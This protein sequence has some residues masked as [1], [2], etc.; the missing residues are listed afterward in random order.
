M[1]TSSDKAPG[2]SAG[3]SSYGQI[4]TSS[5]IVGGAQAINYI[6]G[7][8]RTKLVAVLLGPTGMGLVAV[9]VS[10]IGIVQT[11]AQ[12]GVN[13][14]G[15]REVAAAFGTNNNQRLAETVVALR[16][17]CWITGFAGW[18]LA[19]ALAWPLSQWMF[20]SAEH[21]WAIGILGCIVL[22][23]S[24]ANGQRALLQGIRRI[25]DIARVQIASALIATVVAAV[26]YWKL[27]EA[28][29]VPVIVLTSLIQLGCFWWFA[30]RIH[31]ADP[32]L[33]WRR[34]KDHWVQLIKLG[35]AVLYGG[36]V[37]SAT[38]LVVRAL[39]VRDAGLGGA[40]IYHAA[41]SL[42]GLFGGFVLQ[43]MAMDFLPRLTAIADDNAVVNRLVNE[44]VEI[45]VLL[46]L[47]AVLLPL[48]VAPW[49]VELLFSS[50]FATASDLLPGML[51]GVLCG[52]VRTP[53][54][55]VAIAKKATGYLFALR[56]A[57]G[58]LQVGVFWIM[59]KQFG[60]VGAAWSY[61]LFAAGGVLLSL[62][63]AKRLSDFSCSS[64]TWRRVRFS[65][66]FIGLALLVLLMLQ[67]HPL[68]RVGMML[69][70]AG[71]TYLSMRQLA[72]ISPEHFDARKVLAKITNKIRPRRT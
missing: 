49:L 9:Y 30:R 24:I 43:A 61:A 12:L 23:D 14:S 68:Y 38:G 69:L 65:A 22:I 70:A 15:V 26:L 44:Q 27:G 28:G 36:L 19:I 67:Y 72:L 48:A 31:L 6:I 2:N 5:A 66:T 18:V 59:F 41:W 20:K 11:A 32:Q 39:L 7:L 51:L 35:T 56:T 53:L 21:V 62:L 13:Q 60:L 3:S 17:L 33:S 50:E 34:T 4:L 25:G 47:P 1:S 52:V 10:T 58:L 8:V 16:R 63:L 64:Q 71:A 42:S 29:I 54:T 57:E 45:G 46:A 40:G 55:A 37:L